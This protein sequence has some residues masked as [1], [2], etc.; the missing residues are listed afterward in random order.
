MK[1]AIPKRIGWQEY[2]AIQAVIDGVDQ[3]AQTME[4]K[5]GVGRLELLV[6]DDLREKFRR[7]LRRFNEAITEH[8][9]YKVRQAG[10]GMRRGWAA[11]DKA[12][13]TA[14]AGQLDPAVWEV[15]MPDGRVAA[16]CREN[17]DAYAAT[18]SGRYVDVWTMAEVARIIE[19]FPDIALA[20]TVFPGATVTN[21]RTKRLQEPVG[22]LPFPARAEEEVT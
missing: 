6:G 4:R 2:D 14:G 9:V 19:K 7:Q 18:W 3:V 21:V 12:A 1:Q 10:D 15:R 17:V 8:D 5:W 20:K 11:L 16:F 22:E 13:A